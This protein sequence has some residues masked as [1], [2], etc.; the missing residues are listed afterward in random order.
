MFVAMT[1]RGVAAVD[2]LWTTR[3]IDAKLKDQEYRRSNIR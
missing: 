2:E 1:T 3:T